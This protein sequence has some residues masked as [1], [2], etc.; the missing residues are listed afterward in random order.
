[1][2]VL[3]LKFSGVSLTEGSIVERRP[4]YAAYQQRTNAFFPGWP[5]RA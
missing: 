2:L 4:A 5:K 3:L 1:M